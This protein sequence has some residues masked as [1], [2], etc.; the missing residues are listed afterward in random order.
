ME[1]KGLEGINKWNRVNLGSTY[2]LTMENA[3]ENNDLEL[4][5]NPENDSEN[6]HVVH[7]SDL[8]K[9]ADEKLERLAADEGIAPEEYKRYDR[10]RKGDLSQF[11][12]EDLQA[13]RRIDSKLI[14]ESLQAFKSLQK[15]TYPLAEQMKQIS[16]SMGQ[17]MIA[18][19]RPDFSGLKAQ[20]E[21]VR[22]IQA[23]FPKP[24][25]K[26]PKVDV[27][28]P[29]VNTKLPKVYTGLGASPSPKL[30]S[31]LE[32]RS[33]SGN[34]NAKELNSTGEVD[35][36]HQEESPALELLELSEIFTVKQD[37]QIDL[38]RRMVDLM[39][40]E[41]EASKIRDDRHRNDV[42]E[43]IATSKKTLAWGITAGLAAI[44]GVL[45]AL[46]VA[47]IK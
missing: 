19:I 43:Q 38:I 47:I 37:A 24:E 26:L 40:Q 29:A 5:E 27:K 4:P 30:D 25:I 12:D 13:F 36:K 46:A 15:F 21:L 1:P 42:A 39:A 32:T 14:G 10:S 44:I 34:D 23:T 33:D 45:I 18:S 7:L 28:L 22:K 41:A 31:G 6:A 2:D 3:D 11:S 17:N 16:D 20:Q 35:E 8:Q 9:R